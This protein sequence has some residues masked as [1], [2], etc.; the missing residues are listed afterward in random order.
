MR[1]VI[2]VS[3]V[4]LGLGLSFMLVNYCITAVDRF[5]LEKQV[6]DREIA[7]LQKS[8]YDED[9]DAPSITIV[10]LF[11][12]LGSLKKGGGSNYNTPDKYKK[13]MITWGWLTNHVVAFIEDDETIE[14]F[15][16]IRSQQ[17]AHRTVIVKVNRS[18]LDAFKNLER[19]KQI[20]SN[21]SYPKHS[22]NTINANY[23]C[24]MSA[25]YDVMTMALDMG[26]VKTKYLAWMDIG[27]FR[28]L[29]EEKMKPKNNSFTMEVPAD[30][31]SSR[32]GVTQVVP[33][34]A[35]ERHSPWEFIRHNHVW[36]AGGHVMGTHEVI[37]TF[38]TSYKY[39]S[40]E[41][42]KAG[43]SSTDQQVIGAMYSPQF[44]H[45]QKV[46]VQTYSCVNGQF[47]LH[48]SDALYFCLSYICKEAGER[49]KNRT[50]VL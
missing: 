37:R 7:E 39:V 9:K 24:A 20:Y 4:A 16:Q 45:L 44:R 3:L 30:F 22:P 6:V 17:P 28:N 18:Q 25:K 15:K 12:N 13:W 11:I 19:I 33:R 40:Q 26:L 10:T 23:S 8:L 2:K 29:L 14:Y 36:V 47:G 34:Q 50:S 1:A 43:M 27:L 48:N 21:S 38:I 5:S 35:M 31:N 49:A 41:L 32:V 42:I 46:D